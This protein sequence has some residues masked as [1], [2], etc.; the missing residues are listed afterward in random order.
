MIHAHIGMCT[1]GGRTSTC[2]LAWLLVH[3]FPCCHFGLKVIKAFFPLGTVVGTTVVEK[4][5]VDSR[6]NTKCV[7]RMRD[8][9]SQT[10]QRSLVL[11]RLA[12]A[13][14]AACLLPRLLGRRRHHRRPTRQCHPCRRCRRRRNRTQDR[15]RLH[16][17]VCTVHVLKPSLPA[18]HRGI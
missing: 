12:Q 7:L 5:N 10:W 17:N 18:H 11:H 4:S 16:R 6:A 8:Q 1:Y 13:S 9:I 14:A 2:A 3:A 15:L